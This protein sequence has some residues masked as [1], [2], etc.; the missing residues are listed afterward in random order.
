MATSARRTRLEKAA[1]DAMPKG[2]RHRKGQ[3][4]NERPR[5]IGVSGTSVPAGNDS[6]KNRSGSIKTN[7]T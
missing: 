1:R 2:P 3:N 4:G 7:N 5:A 6:N